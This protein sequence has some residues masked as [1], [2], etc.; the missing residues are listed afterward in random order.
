MR[1]PFCMVLASFVLATAALAKGIAV[2]PDSYVSV[3]LPTPE[4]SVTL[5]IQT[6]QQGF[7]SPYA[8]FPPNDLGALRF[9]ATDGQGHP[10]DL[11]GAR[12]LPAGTYHVVVSAEHGSLSPF[13]LQLR[14]LALSDGFEPNDSAEA[15]RQ[16]DLPFTGVLTLRARD[17]QDW[18]GFDVP[19]PGIVLV[20]L[21]PPPGGM[22]Q[23]VAVQMNA[24]DEGLPNGT[25]RWVEIA[26]DATGVAHR[27]FDVTQAGSWRV[28]AYSVRDSS[29]ADEASLRLDLVFFPDQGAGA[30][31][32]SL[33]ALGV[34][35]DDPNIEQLRL[36]MRA[37]GRNVL[38]TNDPEQIAAALLAAAQPKPQLAE[39]N[40]TLPLTA[41]G[42]LLLVGLAGLGWWLWTRRGRV[43]VAATPNIS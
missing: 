43:R 36:R 12:P 40:W 11:R 7:L 20:R 19:G 37:Q 6:R 31:G 24:Q 32:P 15:L 29:A 8:L 28:K 1:R 3:I 38:V 39:R 42:G 35:P 10:V 41:A 33:V 2:A 4:T 14:S 21:A 25:A 27:Y 26:A 18:F 13:N 30:S 22:G 5:D 9:A 16:V 23:Q 34:A 17:D